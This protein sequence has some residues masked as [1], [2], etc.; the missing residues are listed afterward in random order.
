MPELC[1]RVICAIIQIEICLIVV[2]IKQIRNSVCS[3][4]LHI[5]GRR[6]NR[7]IVL[8]GAGDVQHQNDI[9]RIRIRGDHIACDI[10]IHGKRIRAVIIDFRNG[11]YDLNG[12]AVRRADRRRV[13][14]SHWLFFSSQRRHGQHTEYHYEYKQYAQNSFF[15]RNSSI[16]RFFIQTRLRVI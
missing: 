11:F 16:I 15:H 5:R 2:V 10:G 7:N 6:Y 1:N 3:V 4:R 9:Q 13:D 14:R 12:T 8:H